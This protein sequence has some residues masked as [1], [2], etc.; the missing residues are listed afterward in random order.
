MWSELKIRRSKNFAQSIDF[1]SWFFKV[2]FRFYMTLA[3]TFKLSLSVGVKKGKKTRAV[4]FFVLLP[5]P[6]TFVA[7]VAGK[8]ITALLL[9]KDIYH[10][11]STSH[12]FSRKCPPIN[13]AKC[14]RFSGKKTRWI[15]T[16]IGLYLLNE[17]LF[18]ALL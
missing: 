3:Y 15:L 8:L 16:D 11:S 12:L 7:T 17:E 6:Q 13:R 18:R 5:M 4:C 10:T 9:I 1:N 14:L 2:H